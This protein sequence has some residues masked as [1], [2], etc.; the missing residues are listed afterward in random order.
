MR[1]ILQTIRARQGIIYWGIFLTLIV[2]AFTLYSAAESNSQLSMA[3]LLV[4]I[5]LANILA[6]IV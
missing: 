4:S 3:V 1:K 2:S 6:A 5:V